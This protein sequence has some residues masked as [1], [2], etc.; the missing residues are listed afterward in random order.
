MA[1][2]DL[3]IP[4]YDQ[5]PLT[6]LRHRIRGLD[7][8]QLRAVFDHETERGNRIPV[9]ELINARLRELTHGAEPSPGDPASAPGVTHGEP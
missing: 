7:E 6:E 2:S 3:P 5:Q 9:L 1:Q 8:S 4:D